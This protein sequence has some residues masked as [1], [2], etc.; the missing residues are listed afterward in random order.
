MANWLVIEPEGSLLCSQNFKVWP[1]SGASEH[2][3]LLRSPFLAYFSG[4]KVFLRNA[5]S[6]CVFQLMCTKLSV[7]TFCLWIPCNGRSLEFSSV[8]NNSEAGART[9]GVGA[10]LNCLALKLHVVTD[11]RKV[12]SCYGIFCGM[13]NTC[14][15]TAQKY[16]SFFVFLLF[17]NQAP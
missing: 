7:W 12:C 5:I 3:W 1:R 4:R 11:L 10:A 15:A 17:T 2:T 6:V 9:F 13:W 16:T 14:M 8:R